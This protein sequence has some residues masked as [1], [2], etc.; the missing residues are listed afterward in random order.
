MPSFV[1]VGVF[2]S[3]IGGLTV[4]AALKKELPACRF[5]YLGDNA[6]MPYGS[7]SAEEVYAY[8]Q[9][10]LS[11][12]VRMGASAAVLAC[13][14]ATA[15]CIRR[16]RAA[17]PIPV[18]GVEP[19]LLPA[20]RRCKRVLVLATPQT[21]A[22]ERLR[23]LRAACPACAVTVRALPRFAAAIEGALVRGEKLTLSDHLPRGDYDGVVLGC[24]H[25][26]FFRREIA[27]FYGCEVF[28]GGYGTALRLK[29]VLFGKAEGE[30]FGIY[31]HFAPRVPTQNPNI[32]FSSNCKQMGDG[33]VIF[34]GK[35]RKINRRV[36][37]SNICFNFT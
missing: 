35:G 26:V 22:S 18:V 29:N 28:D 20:A 24:T 32:C 30:S 13:N 8:V 37:Y 1:R 6:H 25:Y 3:G 17:F 16:A 7:R 2:D 21:A 36:Y 34:L 12:F 19:A 5:L 10:A 14:T 15:L 27:D 33:G 23:V 31:D 11:C 4:L 9:S